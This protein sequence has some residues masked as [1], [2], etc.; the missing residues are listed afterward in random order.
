MRDDSTRWTPALGTDRVAEQSGGVTLMSFRPARQTLISG[1]V[2]AALNLSNILS[3]I[4]WPEPAGKDSYALRLRRDRIL[5]VNG[6]ALADGWHDDHGLAVSDVTD[7]Y[8]ACQLNG[9]GALDVVNRG[10]EID[11]TVPSGS[12][13]RRFAGFSVLI[14]A[15]DAASICLHVPH[16]QF[17]GLWQLLNTFRK[18]HDESL[19]TASGV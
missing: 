13:S 19:Q 4:G 8:I 6:P 18:A 12:V 9:P 16:S 5:V 14:Y 2:S 7:G 1:P 15:M 3:A 17:D 10:T 11:W